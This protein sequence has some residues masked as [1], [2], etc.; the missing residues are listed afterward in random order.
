MAPA[1]GHS[2]KTTPF[3]QVPPSEPGLQD[4]TNHKSHS[5]MCDRGGLGISAKPHHEITSDKRCEDALRNE[6]Q[7]QANKR[8]CHP[9]AKPGHTFGQQD[10]RRKAKAADE[11]M[12]DKGGC[13]GQ[14]QVGKLPR[15]RHH[16]IGRLKGK[17]EDQRR[18]Q[19]GISFKNELSQDPCK[20][21]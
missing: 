18:D 13:I 5:D 8:A 17:T 20:Q 16:Q 3:C 1:S 12:D 2:V 7:P 10:N 19:P 4:S 6:P 11:N 14:R 9:A 15:Q 21:E